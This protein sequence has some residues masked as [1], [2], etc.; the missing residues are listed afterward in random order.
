[1]STCSGKHFIS[2]SYQD[3]DYLATHLDGITTATYTEELMKKTSDRGDCCMMS[4]VVWGHSLLE[5][6]ED[7][8]NFEDEDHMN[9]VGELPSGS[10]KLA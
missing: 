7:L 8:A 3:L 10:M 6:E 4:I 1:M 2:C 9:Y 5:Y